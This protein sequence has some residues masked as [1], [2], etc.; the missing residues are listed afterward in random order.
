MIPNFREI[1]F[2]N[3]DGVSKNFITSFLIFCL[4]YGVFTEIVLGW[5]WIP[6][7]ISGLFVS[8][9]FGIPFLFLTITISHLMAKSGRNKLR[10]LP[11]IKVVLDFCFLLPLFMLTGHSLELLSRWI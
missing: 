4:Y 10:W 6:Y 9:F 5:W 11:M 7:L 8:S 3:A 2:Q 1:W